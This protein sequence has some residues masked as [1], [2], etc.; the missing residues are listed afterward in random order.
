MQIFIL[1]HLLLTL[2]LKNTWIEHYFQSNRKP[3]EPPVCS[4]HLRCLFL[5]QIVLITHADRLF[6]FRWRKVFWPCFEEE[7]FFFKLLWPWPW[8]FLW[9]LPRLEFQEM[10]AVYEMKKSLEAQLSGSQGRKTSGLQRRPSELR[11]VVV[12]ADACLPGARQWS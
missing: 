5:L 4:L 11:A 6:L 8:A 7:D 9:L 1:M 2:R 12:S 10:A 3:D